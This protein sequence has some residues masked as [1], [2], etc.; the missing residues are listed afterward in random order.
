MNCETLR[1]RLAENPAVGDE[2]FDRH[3]AACPACRAFRERLLRAEGLIGKALRFDVAGPAAASGE[4]GL[5]ARRPRRVAAVGVAAA[6]LLV[7]LTLWGLGN[8]G[9][10]L[11]P[12]ELARA[13]LEHWDHEP[14]AV[15]RTEVAVADSRLAEV[16]A[17]TAELDLA[18]LDTVSFAK[19]CLIGG[20]LVP[21][22]VVQG[23]AG[24]YMVV[25]LPGRLLDSAVPLKAEALGLAGHILP[26]GRGGIAVLGA[27]SEELE[28]IET[29]VRSAVSWAI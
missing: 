8:D 5:R 10:E 17:G 26:A 3:A 1:D 25:L 7:G 4:R 18:A 29:T 22:F 6:A 27:E 24:P 11:S 20:E 2:S 28:R 9:S 14:E 15:L 19:L 16:L 21:H 12:A 13:V 23:E